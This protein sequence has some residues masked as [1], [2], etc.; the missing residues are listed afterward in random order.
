MF[1]R[2]FEIAFVVVLIGVVVAVVVLAVV[3]SRKDSTSPVVVVPARLVAKR[4]SFS[5]NSG[6]TRYF[7][8][9]EL[10]TGSRAEFGVDGPMYGQS[11]EGDFGQLS[12]QGTRFLWFQRQLGMGPATDYR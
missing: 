1:F 7:V 12:F 2:L 3:R 9:F 11:A 10:E 4:Q 8:T 6:T 5:G